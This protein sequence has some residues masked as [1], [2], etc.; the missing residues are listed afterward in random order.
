MT[1]AVLHYPPKPAPARAA[2]FAI[3]WCDSGKFPFVHVHPVKRADIAPP[4]FYALNRAP[5][6]A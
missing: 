3:E 6:G 5:Q 4:V 2:T 1:A